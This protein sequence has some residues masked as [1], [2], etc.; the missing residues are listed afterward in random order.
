MKNSR[1]RTKRSAD[2][3]YT[4]DYFVELVEKIERHPDVANNDKKIRD[5]T[6]YIRRLEYSDK[7]WTYLLG[8]ADDLPANVLTGLYVEILKCTMTVSIAL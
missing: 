8:T 6:N 3:V 5:V 2:N 4:M 1:S 7:F